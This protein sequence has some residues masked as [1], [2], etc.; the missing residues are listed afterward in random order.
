[1]YEKALTT[2]TLI[3]ALVVGLMAAVWPQQAGLVTGIYQFFSVMLPVLAT[4]ALLKY[5]LKDN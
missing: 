3:V 1:M 4:G 2:I 5:L